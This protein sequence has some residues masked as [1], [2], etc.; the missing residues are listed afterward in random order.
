MHDTALTEI[1]ALLTLALLKSGTSAK[2]IQNAID[3]AATTRLMAGEECV[4]P[5]LEI[6]N[7]VDSNV[8]NIRDVRP[9]ATIA[10]REA[11]R[12][13]PISAINGDVKAL[14][15]LLLLQNGATSREILT[16]LR[17]AAAACVRDSD[18]TIDE[19]EDEFPTTVVSSRSPKA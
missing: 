13:Q 17:M 10:T 15:S 5:A 14:L 11:R 2:D 18:E 4:E 9:G 19:A 7:D 6:R 1:K 3:V 16:T 8:T 12:P